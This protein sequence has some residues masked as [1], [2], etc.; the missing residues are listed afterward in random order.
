MITHLEYSKGV[1]YCGNP[2]LGHSRL[3][4]SY[5]C[6]VK[7]VRSRSYGLRSEGFDL[8]WA[9][10]EGK[11]AICE[12]VFDLE[13]QWPVI[14]H[15]HL[16]GVVRGLLCKGCNSFMAYVDRIRRTMPEAMVIGFIGQRVWSYSERKAGV[17][18][19]RESPAAWVISV[20]T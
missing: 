11:C 3:Y 1:C 8:L 12:E 4:C 16:S 6:Q 13:V 9:E 2:I 17:S 5:P 18:Q 20:G 19:L 15:D 7:A 10:Q 14:D